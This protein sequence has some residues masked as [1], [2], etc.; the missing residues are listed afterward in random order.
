MRNI[1][2]DVC[3]WGDYSTQI[4]RQKRNIRKDIPL[5]VSSDSHGDCKISYIHL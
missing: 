4:I 3:H 5:V 1:T 2:A